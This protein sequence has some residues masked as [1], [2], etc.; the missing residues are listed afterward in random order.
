V[1]RIAAF[2]AAVL[3]TVLALTMAVGVGIASQASPESPS[4]AA[5]AEIPADLL[6]VYMG[7]AQTCPGLPWPVLAAI[8]FV[9]SHHSDGHANPSTGEVSP[10]IYG[11]ALDGSN[12]TARIPD[13]TSPDGWAHALGPMQFLASTWATWG[14]V[15]PGRPA[16]A[17]PDPQNAWDAI[18][19]AAAYLCGPAG[20]ITDLNAAILRYN[21][22][23]AYLQQ[24][25]AKAVQYTRATA[26]GVIMPSGGGVAN[27][28]WLD[29]ARGLLA[30]ISAPDTPSNEATMLTWMAAEQPPSSPNAAFNPLNI[31]A[32][33]YPG[34]GG[35]TGIA[36]T[37]QFN[38]TDWATGIQQTAN[39][40]SQ[41]RYTSVVADF[42]SDAP[43]A[44]TLAA[45]QASG[46]AGGGYGGGLPGL[47]P[48][49]LASFATYATGLIRG[50]R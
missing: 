15:A 28:H 25:L 45:I 29:F 4:G 16:G 36:G 49:I 32:H 38:F 3:V 9:E 50:A 6:R 48:S 21:P 23:P 47:L 39:F 33:G 24:V 1:T 2:T 44:Q 31:Q 20:R 14:R 17:T 46:W 26:V 5:L 7:A 19:S 8:G 35:I 34:E 12:G 37:G 22:S 10:P 41:G 42:R 11:P 18:Y 40:L 27:G 30:A 43:A 13:P